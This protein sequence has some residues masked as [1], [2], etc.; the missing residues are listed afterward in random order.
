[1]TREVS[2]RRALAPV[3]LLCL[4]L[5]PLRASATDVQGTLSSSTVWKKSA[6]PYVLKGDVTVGWG[7]KLVIEP[8]VRVIANR[9]D[10]LR[11]GVD[12]Q[13]VE[14]IVDGTLEVRGTE[15]LPVVF[16][17]RGDVGSW[18]GIRVRGGRGTVIDGAVISQARQGLTLGMSA[19]VRNTSVEATV[20]DCLSVS[21]GKATLE[22]NQLRECGENG[23]TVGEWAKVRVQKTVVTRSGNNGIELRGGGELEHTTVHAN[24][25]SGVVLLSKSELPLVRDSLIT[26]NGAHGVLKARSAR[27]VLLY[28]NVWGNA[29]G[30]YGASAFAG[31]GS[32]SAN[33]HYLSRSDL[34]LRS[35]SPARGVASGGRDMGAFQTPRMVM[36]SRDSRGPEPDARTRSERV[37]AHPRGQMAVASVRG[38][39][40]F[41]VASPREEH[42]GTAVA[43]ARVNPRPSERAD[44]GVASVESDFAPAHRE[45]QLV[46]LVSASRWTGGSGDAGVGRRGRTVSPAP[47]SA[48]RSV[49]RASLKARP[50]QAIPRVA[51]AS[52]ASVSP[53]PVESRAPIESPKVEEPVVPASSPP[54]LSELSTALS[55]QAWVP[56]MQLADGVGPGP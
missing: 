26:S 56:G 22:G 8:G 10:A 48:P 24:G 38:K 41:P 36:V 33:P 2:W 40:I 16:T 30:D 19:V 31:P 34:R 17:S 39:Q 23:L 4:S 13:R 51:A 3:L 27:G 1:V 50:P 29:A 47:K 43:L 12:P 32:I 18:Y 28:N 46:M 9:Q 42:E 5:L 53:P 37:T 49:S 52:P 44:T 35:E 55:P 45:P 14:L 11:S 21:W 6:S 25:A 54:T 15:A 20:D 7:V